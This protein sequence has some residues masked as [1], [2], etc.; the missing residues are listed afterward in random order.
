MPTHE[1]NG[2][3]AAF[4]DAYYGADRNAAP[5]GL[6]PWD[7][8][9]PGPRPTAPLPSARRSGPKP[10]SPRRQRLQ[11]KLASFLSACSILTVILHLVHR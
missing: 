7:P 1:D 2:H 3:R 6:P 9:P 5:R 4:W 11:P 10:L 8:P